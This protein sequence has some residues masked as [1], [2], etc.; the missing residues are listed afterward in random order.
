MKKLEKKIGILKN[1]F[2][3]ARICP[4][5]QANELCNKKSDCE[6]CAD[7]FVDGLLIEIGRE[8]GREIR[9]QISGALADKTR[10]EKKRNQMLKYRHEEL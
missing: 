7:D 2:R 1:G 10:S 8:T 5:G 6:E 4:F 3:E 9:R